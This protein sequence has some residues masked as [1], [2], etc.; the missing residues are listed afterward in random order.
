M[1]LYI[2]RRATPPGHRQ[3]ACTA[4]Q[5]ARHR[6]PGL[7]RQRETISL[8]TAYSDLRHGP[9]HISRPKSML[10]KTRDAGTVRGVQ[11]ACTSMETKRG[12]RELSAIIDAQP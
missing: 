5:G 7:Q 11:A 10:L 9:G 12:A 4:E 3:S 6:A 2:G 1:L 8:G